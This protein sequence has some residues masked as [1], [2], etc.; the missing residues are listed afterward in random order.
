[1]RR[2]VTGGHSALII[3]VLLV[4]F[5]AGAAQAGGPEIL[6]KEMR[7]ELGEVFQEDTFAH[8]FKVQNIGDAD[9]EIKSV[10]PG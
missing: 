8:T 6:I 1:M 10:K 2:F 7:F 5:L 3:A 4:V 9:L